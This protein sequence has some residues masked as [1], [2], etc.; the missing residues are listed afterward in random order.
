MPIPVKSLTFCATLRFVHSFNELW[1]PN[2]LLHMHLLP[3]QN[4]A[5]FYFQDNQHQHSPWPWYRNNQVSTTPPST[6]QNIEHGENVELQIDNS[7]IWITN[8]SLSMVGTNDSSGGWELGSVWVRTVNFLDKIY[9]SYSP[10][11]TRQNLIITKINSFTPIA[12][13]HS[14]TYWI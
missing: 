14:H 6:K 10:L 3:F 12:Y 1:Q 4:G 5:H 2:P 9:S 11:F 8:C 13:V 7:N